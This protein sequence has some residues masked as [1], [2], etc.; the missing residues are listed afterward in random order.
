LENDGLGLYC[1]EYT[2]AAPTRGGIVLCHPF[3]EEKLWSQRIFVSFARLLAR[4]G[5]SVLRVDYRGH[6][7]SEGEFADATI[8]TRIS[9][10]ECALDYLK[11]KLGPGAPLG[12][13]GLR[14]GATLAALCT[15][16]RNDVTFLILW[17]PVVQG[18]SYL[19]Q[20]LRIN[21]ATQAAVYKQVLNNSDALVEKLRRGETVNIDG[22]EIGHDF[23][24]QL[25]ALDLLAGDTH[26]GGN[27][28]LLSIAKNAAKVDR[29]L[30]RLKQKYTNGSY[31]TVVEDGFW[32]SVPAY[33]R[34]ADNL[35]EHTLRWMEAGND[36]SDQVS[37]Q[38]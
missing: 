36:D 6:G 14:L 30:L 15:E 35:F 9:D 25:N 13:T 11:T 26:F 2:P 20:L 8:A 37:K 28:L 5:Y 7:D 38:A 33:C 17:E 10:I 27:V 12:L 29:H 31:A 22:Y 32:N 24:E 19:R 1:I 18:K 3:A 4:N 21:I 34:S 16:K 23:Y